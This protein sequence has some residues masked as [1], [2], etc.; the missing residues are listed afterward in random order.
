[1][2]DDYTVLPL[3]DDQGKTWRSVMMPGSGRVHGNIVELSPGNLICLLRS[4][5]C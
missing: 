4:Q 5:L 1:M 3:S 2:G